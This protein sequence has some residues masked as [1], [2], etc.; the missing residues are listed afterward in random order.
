MALSILDDKPKKL[1]NDQLT[2]ML[3]GEKYGKDV[4]K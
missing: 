2:G 3:F 1:D 4:L